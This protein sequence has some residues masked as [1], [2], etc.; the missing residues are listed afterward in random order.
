M[1]NK[2]LVWALALWMWGCAMRENTG[3]IV[4]GN[5]DR[6]ALANPQYPW[7]EENYRGYTSDQGAVAVIRQKKEGV[8]ALIF[9]GTWCGDSRREVPRFYKVVD[10]A[11]FSDV[12][13]VG[14]DRKKKS[15]DGTESGYHI[16]RVPTFIFFK[17]D[18]EIGRI[19]E[20]PTTTLE[21]DISRILGSARAKGD[22]R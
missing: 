6:A 1:R 13:I 19:V 15:P 22:N 5:T 4:T 8:S 21:E 16:E 3:A 12:R 20:T 11:E 18:K 17:N 10:M 9:L 7:F 2:A 14:L